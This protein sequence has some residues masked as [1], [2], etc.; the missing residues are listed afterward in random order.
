[1]GL[2][3]QLFGVEIRHYQFDEYKQNNKALKRRMLVLYV[4]Q[5]VATFLFFDH[6]DIPDKATFLKVLLIWLVV[7]GVFFAVSYALWSGKLSQEELLKMYLDHAKKEWVTQ[8]EYQLYTWNEDVFFRQGMT[9][10]DRIEVKIGETICFF[11]VEDEGISLIECPRVDTEIIVRP[12]T[13]GNPYIE[14]QAEQY[15]EF[16]FFD[17]LEETEKLTED[18]KKRWPQKRRIIIHSNC[19]QVFSQKLRP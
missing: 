5:C 16:G 18:E 4:V 10:E 15:E 6:I 14:C 11:A 17:L 3:K 7:T 12:V 1:M 13:E 2:L 9:E 8:K 19:I